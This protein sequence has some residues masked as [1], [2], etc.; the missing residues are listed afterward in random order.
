MVT[1]RHALT[2]ALTAVAT[3]LVPEEASAETTDY[4]SF[5]VYNGNPPGHLAWEADRETYLAA[6][7]WVVGY[8]PI[9]M[10]ETYDTGEYVAV[11]PP[12]QIGEWLRRT[13]FPPDAWGEPTFVRVYWTIGSD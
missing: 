10:P 13:R 7:A 2:A 8:E 6:D 3:Q 12:V 9:G 11:E 4:F 5:H 1:R